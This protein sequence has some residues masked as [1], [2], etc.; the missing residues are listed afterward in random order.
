MLFSARARTIT[1][2]A[3]P[4]SGRGSLSN[5]QRKDEPREARTP[6]SGIFLLVKTSETASVRV[7]GLC[8]FEPS[9]ARYVFGTQLSF[10]HYLSA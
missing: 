3:L 9:F 6:H 7:E 8:E 10:K 5:P 1:V 4:A 2:L